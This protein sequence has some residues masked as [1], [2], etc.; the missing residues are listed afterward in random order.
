MKQGRRSPVALLSTDGGVVF[1]AYSHCKDPKVT[2]TDMSFDVDRKIVWE[3]HLV[4]RTKSGA[5]MIAID[6]ATEGYSSVTHDNAML[7]RVLAPDSDVVLFMRFT[8]ST[9]F[10]VTGSLLTSTIR[11]LDAE[12]A[13]YSA[14]IV[15][16]KELGC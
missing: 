6:K 3:T 16:R 5:R 14:V 12:S 15:S 1:T 11:K 8:D 10:E 7:E 4:D 9:G 2:I 13:V